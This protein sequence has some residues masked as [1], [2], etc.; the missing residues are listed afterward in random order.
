MY[1]SKEKKPKTT[2]SLQQPESPTKGLTQTQINNVVDYKL[3]EAFR[4]I[5]KENLLYF[6]TL[7]RMN[8]LVEKKFPA[9]GGVAFDANRSKIY[10]ILR[11]DTLFSGSEVDVAGLC[12]HECGHVLY[13]HIFAN[14][15]FVGKDPRT[16]NQAQDYI[17][18]DSC[19]YIT[20]RLKDIQD[21]K[22]KSILAGGCFYP[23]LQK[24]IPEL[25][26]HDSSEMTS[27]Y[28]YGFLKRH[29]EEQKKNQ[30]KGQ[31]GKG[32]PQTGQ[33]SPSDEQG[34]S[35]DQDSQNQ[36]GLGELLDSHD[37]FEVRLDENGDE[38]IVNLN[39]EKKELKENKPNDKKAQEKLD[40]KMDQHK[41]QMSEEM[42]DL[43][44]QVID[45][46][47]RE[48][49]LQKA[50][51]QLKGQIKGL[52]QEMVKSKLN[53]NACL[54][55]INRMKLGYKKTWAVLDKRYP[56]LQ[57][58][59][60]KNKKPKIGVVIDTSGSMGGDKLFGMINYQCQALV[61]K[62]QQLY[63][64]VGDTQMEY[65]LFIK[66][67]RDFKADTIKFSGLG[68]TDLQFGWDFAK[69]NKLDGLIIHTDGYIGEFEDHGIKSLFYLYGSSVMEQEG[70]ENYRVL[71][72]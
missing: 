51:G 52:V 8:F 3:Y 11:E 16:L 26:Q 21:P 72:D 39:E 60:V 19:H 48:N 12:E 36:D 61:N 65:S 49:L 71:P 43:L 13:E 68:G 70:Y 24:Q 38:K 44:S 58:G 2:I 5:E 31:K 18:N 62:C 14:D 20:K 53:R 67:A 17:I 33:G 69:E 6:R 59:K 7:K 57:K 63:I 30:Q 28:L 40:Q 22:T 9:I 15:E 1:M 55:F 46:L 34:E 10:M 37:Q 35:G 29:K 32:Q 66:K 27:L 50:I 47:D 25:K 64:I 42:K 41:K 23:E 56:Y 4:L 45:E 54:S